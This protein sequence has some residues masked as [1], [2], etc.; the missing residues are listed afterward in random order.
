MAEVLDTVSTSMLL[1]GSSGLAIIP[2]QQ[3]TNVF[4]LCIVDKDP[5]IGDVITPIF[6]T[7]DPQRDTVAEVNEYVKGNSMDFLSSDR[8]RQLA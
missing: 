4:F 1:L 7:C 8:N 6:I 2:I 3:S 5:E